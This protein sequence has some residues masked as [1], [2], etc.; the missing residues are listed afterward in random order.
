MRLIDSSGP[1]G[2]IRPFFQVAR[3][4]S[5]S[6]LLTDVTARTERWMHWK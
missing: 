5:M 2:S 4:T 1:S 3:T 6:R